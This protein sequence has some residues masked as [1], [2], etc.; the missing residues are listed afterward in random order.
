MNASQ[1]LWKRLAVILPADQ[2]NWLVEEH[3]QDL[4]R[5]RRHSTYRQKQRQYGNAL[6]RIGYSL[7]KE[8]AQQQAAQLYKWLCDHK[9]WNPEGCAA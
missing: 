4:S 1:R 9:D 3:K 8:A 7:N 6:N 5:D 2:F